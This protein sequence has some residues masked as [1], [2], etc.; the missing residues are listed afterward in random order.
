MGG[1]KYHARKWGG[2]DSKR[3]ARRAQELRLLEKAGRISDLREQVKY[4]L[5][6]AQWAEEPRIGKRGQP[7]KPRRRCI[8]RACDYI[9]D[10]VYRL[11]S[12]EL[13]VEDAK[14]PATR[15]PEYIIKRKLMLYVHGIKI[16]EV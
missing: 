13:I 8:E 5:I 9:A 11:P 1:N 12:G 16:V 3:E 15:T 10:F 2:Y 6:P 14:S 7:L 4:E